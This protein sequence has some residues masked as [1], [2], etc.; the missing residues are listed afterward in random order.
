M[1]QT[2]WGFACFLLAIFAVTFTSGCSNSRMMSISPS[3]VALAPGQTAQFQLS[4]NRKDVVWSVEASLEE[5]RPWGRSTPTAITL[6]RP[7]IQAPRHH[8]G[9]IRSIICR[10]AQAVIVAPGVVT[11]T[12]NP[13]WRCTRSRRRPM[14]ASQFSLARLQIMASPHGRNLRQREAARWRFSLPGC[15]AT[16]RTTCRRR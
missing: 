2:R 3:V 16:P 8:Y 12:A 13:R 9:H 6:P 15:L 14:R 7:R 11:P 1:I 10:A 4:D 5:I